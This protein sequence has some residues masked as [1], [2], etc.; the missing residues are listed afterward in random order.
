MSHFFS[1]VAEMTPRTVTSYSGVFL[2]YLNLLPVKLIRGCRVSRLEQRGAQHSR[3]HYNRV[4]DVAVSEMSSASRAPPR[5]AHSW[6][7]KR[8]RQVASATHSRQTPRH[9]HTLTHN[10]SALGHHGSSSSQTSHKVSLYVRC[11]LSD[12]L[13]LMLF[14]TYCSSC[15][16]VTVLSRCSRV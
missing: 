6:S 1:D 5:S 10:T 4:V 13:K 11:N 9:T 14:S 3:L 8:H 15:W 16:H 12:T 7:V 2:H